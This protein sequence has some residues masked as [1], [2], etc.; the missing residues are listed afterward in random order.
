MT[1]LGKV[2]GGT[3]GFAV[4]GPLGAIAG[5]AFGHMFDKSEDMDLESSWRDG[6]LSPDEQAQFFFF[7]AAFSM[8]AKLVRL[9]G[10]INQKELDSIKTIMRQDLK[11]PPDSQQ[12]ALKV[13]HAALNSPQTFEEFAAEFYRHFYD[14]PHLLELM[15]DILIRV[16]ISDGELTP[17]EEALIRSAAGIF[18]MSED[19]FRRIRSRHIKTTG[20]GGANNHYAIL[21]SSPHDTDE[22]IKHA[23]R[24][25]A[26][27][28]HPDKIASKGL[29]EEFHQFANEKFRQIQE[30]Y[31]AIKK[32]RGIK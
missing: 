12:H 24:K 5:A 27:D 13:F 8:L 2:V 23:F 11:L 9:D 26:A 1:W 18:R 19:Q 16:G 29:P 28:F 31:D 22:Q 15:M 7:V 3:L 10:V 4:G 17:A 30:A 20:A 6:Y 32:E 14:Q 25:L 21:K